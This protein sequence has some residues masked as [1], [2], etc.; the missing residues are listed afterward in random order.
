MTWIGLRDKDAG[1]FNPQGL[2]DTPTQP[3]MT[4]QPLSDDRLITRG[5][6]LMETR[7]TPGRRPQTLL[8]FASNNSWPVQMSL[9]STPNC[10]VSFVLD[11]AG[12]LT[13]GTVSLPLTERLETLQI[14]YSW[15]APQKWGRLILSHVDSGTF[16]VAQVSAPTPIRLAD[17]QA[18]TQAQNACFLSPDVSFLAVSTDIEP[19]GPS[20]SLAARTPIE[21]PNGPIPV[22]RLRRGDTVYSD[23]GEIVP[24]LHSLARTVPARGTFAPVRLRSPYFG[25][26]RDTVVA[27]TQRI[28]LSG[29]VV[30]YMFGTEAVLASANHL[31]GGITAKMVDAGPVITYYHILL[32]QHQTIQSSGISL[33][34]LYIGR[35]RRKKQQLAATIFANLD[36]AHL[37]EHA[38]PAFPIIRQ[39][40]ALVLAEQRSA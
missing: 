5:S 8:R 13:H 4:T 20:P 25:L 22:S 29:S 31:A 11:Q 27:P 34:S 36:R 30:D 24:V 19:T 12:I 15:D 2:D 1:Y 37:P 40:D 39:F 17:I 38:A 26:L 6:L 18:L 28:K 21:T 9:S 3:A 10:G 32:P 7:L 14:T 16:A 33:E 35:I 23:T